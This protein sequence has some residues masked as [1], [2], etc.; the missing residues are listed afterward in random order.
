MKTIA[1]ALWH[2]LL[3]PLVSAILF[4]GVCPLIQHLLFHLWG[5]LSRLSSFAILPSDIYHS[6]FMVYSP[7]WCLLFHLWGLPLCLPAFTI[8][9]FSLFSDIYRPAFRCLPLPILR[10]LPS[11]LPVFTSPPSSGFCA[12]LRCLL[13]CFSVSTP[14][15]RCLLSHLSS[16]AILPSGICY[17]A[18][19]VAAC[20]SPFVVIRSKIPPPTPMPDRQKDVFLTQSNHKKSKRSKTACFL[21]L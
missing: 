9:S 17:S 14:L 6:S 19:G 13:F 2:L 18:F 4:F 16:F 3:S 8:L 12:P 20:F 7:L 10:H 1:S 15:I 5:L 21:L 11:C